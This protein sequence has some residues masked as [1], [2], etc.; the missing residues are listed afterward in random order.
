MIDYIVGG[1]YLNVTSNKGAQPY[2][3]LSQ[4]ITGQLS[5]DG[6]SQTMK[7]FDGNSWQTIGGGSATV[8]LN[9]NAISVLKWAEQKMREEYE[10]KA[11]ADQNPAIK[12]L[13]N[14]MT[15]SIADYKH[16]IAMVKALTQIQAE[17]TTVQASP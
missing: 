13:V 8:N 4:P 9:G 16:K 11:L 14:Q 15:T 6:S 1:E 3:S 5:Y 7:V 10:L 2:I 12:D 17:E